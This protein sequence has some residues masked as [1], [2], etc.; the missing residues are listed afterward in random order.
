MAISA[1]DL[2]LEFPQDPYFDYDLEDSVQC[3]DDSDCP[4]GSKCPTKDNIKMKN[5]CMCVNELRPLKKDG[6][7]DQ[8]PKSIFSDI[9]SDDKINLN[10]SPKFGPNQ[11][12]AKSADNVTETT[13]RFKDEAPITDETVITAL[14]IFIPLAAVLILGTIVIFVIFRQCRVWKRKKLRRKGNVIKASDNMQ[15]LDKMNVVNK[16]PSYLETNKNLFGGKKVTITNIPIERIKLLDA[17]G[18]GAFGQVFKGELHCPETDTSQNIAVKVL[19]DG[20][21]NEAREDFERE[22]EI[23]SAFDHDNILE[24]LGIVTDTTRDTPYMV[25][26]Y[27][28]HGDLAELL[29]KTDPSIRGTEPTFPLRKVDLIFITTQISNGMKYLTSQHFVHRDLATR[30]CLVGEGLVVKIS[31]F[32]MARDIYTCDYYRI[33]GSRMLPVRWMSPEAVKWGRFTTESDIWAYGV[34]LWEIFN[35]GRQPYYGHSNEEVIRFLDEGILLQRPGECPSTVYHVML[36]CWKLDPKERLPF[37][38]IHK[39]LTEYSK[40]ISRNGDSLDIEND[41][42][43][44]I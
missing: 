22:V 18:E 20:V 37:H 30:N 42:E 10:L 38:R 8:D 34:V 3:Q 36:Q 1:L 21:S 39:Y 7:C 5:I 14:K 17:V 23:M 32:G 9:N 16:N 15:L 6:S 40:Q 41:Y 24:L 13:S 31:D 35:Y 19:K 26:E 33:G 28:L 43:I 25:F 12:V 44:P 27:M 29:R 4:E 2:G 11:S